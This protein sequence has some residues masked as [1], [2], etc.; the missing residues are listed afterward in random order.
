MEEQEKPT[1]EPVNEQEQPTEAAPAPEAV[2]PSA[3]EDIKKLK[4]ELAE[5][6]DKFLRMYA[7]FENHRRR[8][9]K[10]RLELISTANEQL[11]R[12]L[13]PVADDLD[14]AE[15]SFREAGTREAE[16]VLLIVNKFRKTLEQNGLKTM[17]T[18]SGTFDPD[19][20]EAIT[21]IPS[22]DQ[23]GKII[24]VVEKGYLLNEKVIRHA[25]VVVGS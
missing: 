10:E 13:L 12:A 25:K 24:D 9:A 4:D 11:M 20:H 15:K 21:Q 5:S 1:Q 8:T 6:K 17:D 14:R 23:D 19:L 22:P 2:K 3:E 16:G 18:S 7:E